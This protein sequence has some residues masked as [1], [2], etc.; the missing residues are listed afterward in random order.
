MKATAFVCASG[1]LFA[2]WLTITY[3]R[4]VS[5]KDYP[6]LGKGSVPVSAQRV[7]PAVHEGSLIS[8]EETR[9]APVAHLDTPSQEPGVFPH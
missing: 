2:T 8:L 1:A 6:A 3:V 7:A 9:E 5:P 4:D